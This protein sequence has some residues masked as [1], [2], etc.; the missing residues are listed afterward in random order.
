MNAI[1]KDLEQGLN[2]LGSRSFAEANFLANKILRALKKSLIQDTT[3]SMNDILTFVI[4]AKYLNYFTTTDVKK[5]NSIEKEILNLLNENAE[6]DLII[7]DAIIYSFKRT[8]EQ[9]KKE[10][11]LPE[12][13]DN[14]ND[15]RLKFVD[16]IMEHPSCYHEI[17]L[18]LFLQLNNVF[19]NIGYNSLDDALRTIDEITTKLEDARSRAD[20]TVKKLLDVMRWDLMIKAFNGGIITDNDVREN[21]ISEMTKAIFSENIGLHNWYYAKIMYYFA[22]L[23]SYKFPEELE[24]KITPDMIFEKLKKSLRVLWELKHYQ[25]YMMSYSI[26]LS[27]LVN[28]LMGTSSLDE[29]N[30]I[31]KEII[32]DVDN[33]LPLIDVMFAGVSSGIKNNLFASLAA[34]ATEVETDYSKELLKASLQIFISLEREK[35]DPRIAKKIFGNFVIVMKA[36]IK[37]IPSAEQAVLFKELLGMLDDMIYINY[38]EGSSDYLYITYHYLDVLR[39]YKDKLSDKFYREAAT[40]VLKYIRNDIFDN[41]TG[42][43][44]GRVAGNKAHVICRLFELY[45]KENIDPP[46]N[47]KDELK[48]LLEK[49]A[50]SIVQYDEEGQNLVKRARELLQEQN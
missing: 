33:I 48:S 7:N 10:S 14:I 22:F 4:A 42:P 12:A 11:L 26:F 30:R 37:Y 17:A 28:K 41:V 32:K 13:R 23:T 24:I 50:E 5:R 18:T 29:R 47:L 21:L 1:K 20:P 43:M 31:V 8:Y 16:W 6:R 9:L 40:K 34:I 38:V 49:T 44:L 45:K 35:L 3:I 2:A 39:T 46:T 25:S 15:L 19:F 27:A 36:M